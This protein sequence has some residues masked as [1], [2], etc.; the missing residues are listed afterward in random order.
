VAA[1]SVWSA[2]IYRR[3]GIFCF[4]FFRSCAFRELW[5]QSVAPRRERKKKSRETKAAINRRTPKPKQKIP[6]RR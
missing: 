5:Q 4:C 1:F 3:F 6:K 2:A